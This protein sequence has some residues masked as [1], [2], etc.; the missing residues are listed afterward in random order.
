M[1][2]RLRIYLATDEPKVIEEAGKMYPQFVFLTTSHGGRSSGEGERAGTAHTQNLL[3]D[4][5]H[6]AKADFFVGTASSQVSRCPHLSPP[7]PPTL[8]LSAQ[9]NQSLGVLVVS[10]NH[11]MAYER[12]QTH[13]LDRHNWRTFVSLDSP[14]YFP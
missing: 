8:W 12:Q 5:F 10:H 6:L 14:W 1:T 11:R 3:S 2:E 13:S 7:C 4:L 9:L